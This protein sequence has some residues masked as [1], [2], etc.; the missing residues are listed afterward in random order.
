MARFVCK[1]C[2]YKLEDGKGGRCPYCSME[3]L[4]KEQ[5]AEK[6]IKEV[7]KILE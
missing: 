5:E 3:S 1:N 6:L 7:E 2:G 4:E